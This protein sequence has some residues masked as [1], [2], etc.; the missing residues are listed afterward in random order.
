M[1][2]SFDV[3]RTDV[4]HGTIENVTYQSKTF[5]TTRKATVY[6]P[7]HYYKTNNYPVLY[8]LPDSGDD[9]KRWV[10]E[11]HINILMDNL[12]ELQKVNPIVIVMPDGSAAR[13]GAN[14]TP[15]ENAVLAALIEKDAQVD[16]IP[17]IEKN[18][19]VQTDW[20]M[21]AIAGIGSSGA[22]ALNISL[23]DPRQFAWTAAFSVA[24]NVK[25]P[26]TLI[27]DGQRAAGFI[28]LSCG[29]DD[30]LLTYSKRTH[31][32]FAKN[33]IPHVYYLQPG[34]Q[35]F[36]VWKNNFYVFSQWLFKPYF[37]ESLGRIAYQK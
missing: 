36:N 25:A 8:L 23:G 11:G 16:L 37:V 13:D 35:D 15:T 31:E 4:V 18:Y 14:A 24:K 6:L 34:N 26:E 7:P 2:A 19:A 30:D 20:Q 3:A 29:N 28:W 9:E 22:N 27:P 21:R 33:N 17:F 12:Y 1:P 5:G 10:N 32:Y